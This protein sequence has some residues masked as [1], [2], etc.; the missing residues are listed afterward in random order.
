VPDN[1]KS[2]VRPHGTVILTDKFSGKET[3]HDTLQCC[4]C[5]RHWI[6]VK[7]SGKRRGWCF[8]CNGPTC[9]A[10]ACMDHIPAEAQLEILEGTRNPGS[11]SVGMPGKL[12]VP[13]DISVG[14]KKEV[15]PSEETKPENKTSRKIISID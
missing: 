1:R 12:W 5:M 10:D 14:D 8:R 3:H 2:V 15:K 9:G 13:D 7:G 11:V 4:H 6:V